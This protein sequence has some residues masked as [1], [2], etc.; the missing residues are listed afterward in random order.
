MS[1]DLSRRQALRS[2]AALSL[3]LPLAPLLSGC[4]SPSLSTPTTGATPLPDLPAP[5]APLGRAH[6]LVGTLWHCATRQT[7]LTTDLAALLARHRWI[8]LG[9]THDNPDHHRF[10]GWC[11]ATATAMARQQGRPLPA[12]VWEMITDEQ[13]AALDSFMSG[14]PTAAAMGPA[15]GWE[16]TGWP[17]WSLYQPIAES[18]L[19]LSLP[20][21]LPQTA[22]GLSRTTTRAIA[23]SGLDAV[24]SPVD[25][26]AMALT[27][28]LPDA[29]RQAQEE[30]LRVGHCGMM[31]EQM[32]QPMLTIQTAKDAVMAH[33]LQTASSAA[34]PPGSPAAQG[35]LIAGSGHA[36]RD[37]GVPL[38]LSRQQADGTTLVVL[39]QEVEDGLT[40]P[41]AYGRATPEQADVVWF[42]PAAERDDPCASLKRPPA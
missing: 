39:C 30:E 14:T 37:L 38:H 41:A 1:S 17:D 7:L 3:S 4:A 34:T 32:L 20:H 10:Q 15:L 12:M 19:A 42:T 29:V 5:T 28:P 23:R 36:R 8:M 16:Q 18:A 40:D 25:Q 2:F 9:E 13:A 33:T 22:G 31:P 21:P 26:A 35:L 27:V 24:F 11:V 6:P